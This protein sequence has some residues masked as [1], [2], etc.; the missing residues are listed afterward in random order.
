MLKRGKII[1]GHGDHK[2]HGFPSFTIA[3]PVLINGSRGNVAVVVQ[4]QGK[5]KYHAH[6]ILLPDGSVFVIKNKDAEL[7][8]AS[9]TSN[10][11]R[12]RLP[13]SSASNNSI[14]Q[15]SDL[16]TQIDQ[17]NSTTQT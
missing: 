14:P 4:Q 12:Q 5:N 15:K 16:S 10:E 8:T 3:A 9:M 13:N 1:S 2:S 7:S 11:T 17:K 6:R